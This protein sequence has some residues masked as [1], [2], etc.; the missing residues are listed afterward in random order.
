MAGI[1]IIFHED[2]CIQYPIVFLAT[3]I[4]NIAGH[5]GQYRKYTYKSYR[6]TLK[7]YSYAVSDITT[8]DT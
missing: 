7:P 5:H 6:L 8:G 1:S 3:M 2:H 4:H